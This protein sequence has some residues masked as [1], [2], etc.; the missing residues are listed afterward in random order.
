MSPLQRFLMAGI[1]LA[2]FAAPSRAAE[3]FTFQYLF[4]HAYDPAGFFSG[5]GTLTT[6]DLD[7]ATN[8]YLIT[9]VDGARTVSAFGSTTTNTITGLLPPGG[10]AGN[11]NLLYAFAPW[12]LDE[13]GFS[14]TISDPTGG[15][16]GMGRVNVYYFGY[17]SYSEAGAAAGFGNFTATLVQTPEVPEPAVGVLVVCGLACI[18]AGRRFS[19][20]R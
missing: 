1:L 12:F 5:S 4:N 11:S 18:A 20:R 16:D 13:G 14:F 7:P 15:S 19:R 2:A 6:D 3:V 8:T 10:Y 17:S 9:G